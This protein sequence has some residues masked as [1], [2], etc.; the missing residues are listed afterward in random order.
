MYA[1]GLFAKPITGET[2]EDEH[3]LQ[4]LLKKVIARMI[5]TK[6]GKITI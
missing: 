1:M 5:P 2:T 4:Q 6:A 3:G